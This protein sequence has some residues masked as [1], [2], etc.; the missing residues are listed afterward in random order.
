MNGIY[1]DTVHYK[2]HNA[3]CTPAIIISHCKYANDGSN[4]KRAGSCTTVRYAL[5]TNTVHWV[6]QRLWRCS[7]IHVLYGATMQPQ[8]NWNRPKQWSAPYSLIKSG[9][10]SRIRTAT[11]VSNRLQA[12]RRSEIF[13]FISR[14]SLVNLSATCIYRM[15]WGRGHFYKWFTE[16]FSADHMYCLYCSIHVPVWCHV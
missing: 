4:L 1:Q 15:S 3:S 10:R 8:G 12:V 5:N 13:M 16:L 2:R 11:R 9:G 7:M 14:Y 6:C